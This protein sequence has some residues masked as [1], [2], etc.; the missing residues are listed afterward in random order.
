MAEG[1]IVAGKLYLI[2]DIPICTWYNICLPC[3]VF[4]HH[5]RRA[6]IYI[7]MCDYYNN[8]VDLS[9]KK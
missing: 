1:C 9:F 4:Y 5:M 2:D 6:T 7:L 3:I 8:Y